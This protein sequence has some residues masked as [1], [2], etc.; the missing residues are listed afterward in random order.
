MRRAIAIL[1][2]ITA[3][4]S[5]VPVLYFFIFSG[6]RRY[7]YPATLI[8][9]TRSI[10]SLNQV[11]VIHKEEASGPAAPIVASNQDQSIVGVYLYNEDSKT[12]DKQN[13]AKGRYAW[14]CTMGLAGLSHQM[15]IHGIK[16]PICDPWL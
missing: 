13:H 6:E 2:F 4:I 14:H 5:F 8:Q 1:L 12:E 11:L 10:S 15:W 7:I 16:T 9:N 3:T